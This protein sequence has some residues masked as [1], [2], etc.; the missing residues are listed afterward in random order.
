MTGSLS[1]WEP[2]TIRDALKPVTIT[3]TITDVD[4]QVAALM[5]GCSVLDLL[6]TPQN[7]DTRRM[8]TLAKADQ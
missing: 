8:A 1:D 6:P 7:R 3:M 4:W 5:L 2:A